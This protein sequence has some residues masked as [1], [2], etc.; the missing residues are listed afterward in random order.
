VFIYLLHLGSGY[1]LID[2]VNT[3]HCCGQI[4]MWHYI[5]V[6]TGTIAFSVWRKIDIS[7]YKVVALR[8]SVFALRNS[9][10]YQSVFGR[11][12]ILLD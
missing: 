7:R 2:P 8:R 6:K 3:V 5:P 1:L 4:T 10:E 12:M 11:K 9:S